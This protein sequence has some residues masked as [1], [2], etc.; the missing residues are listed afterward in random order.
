MDVFITNTFEETRA[1][2]EKI[3]KNL[4]G[5]EVLAL[6]G[7]LGAGKT[8]FVQGM[9]KGLGLKRRIISPTFIIVRSYNLEIMNFYHIDLYRV[10]NPL[11]IKKLGLDEIFNNP[12]SIVAIEWAEK[13]GNLLPKRRLD[14]FFEYLSDNRRKIIIKKLMH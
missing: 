4:K 8:T 6:Y 9:T 2:G 1:L 7:N 11:D 13:M 10:E 12:K 3:A 5:G 14:I